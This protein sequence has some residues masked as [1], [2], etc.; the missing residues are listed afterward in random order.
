MC[1]LERLFLDSKRLP[2]GSDGM[3]WNEVLDGWVVIQK[4]LVREQLMQGLDLS[5]GSTDEGR[6][7]VPRG[8]SHSRFLL[9]P[10]SPVQSTGQILV[11][12]VR[13]DNLQSK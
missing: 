11:P 12:N 3:G 1:A 2:F 4:N 8:K 5:I 10:Q 6:E 9:K 7:R 13:H